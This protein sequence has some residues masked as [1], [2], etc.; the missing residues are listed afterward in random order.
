[1]WLPVIIGTLSIV[2]FYFLAKEFTEDDLLA[3]IATLSFAMLP[4]TATWITMG[5]GITR[6]F[7]ILFAIL[8]MLFGYRLF[9]RGTW[10]EVIL[11]A[12]SASLLVLS[13]PEWSIQTVGVILLFFFV[14]RNKLSCSHFDPL[15][16][17]ETFSLL[18]GPLIHTTLQSLR[19]VSGY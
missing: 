16:D 14:Q 1:M 5:E 6:S 3:A 10:L 4:P 11:T 13:H 2:V 9:Q 8:T 19:S 12:L 7:G 18:T 15:V 17:T